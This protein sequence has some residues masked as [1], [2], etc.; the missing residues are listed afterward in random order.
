MCFIYVEYTQI[1]Y[2]ESILY[3]PHTCSRKATE[4]YPVEV[5]TMLHREL[6]TQ[7][8]SMHGTGWLWNDRACI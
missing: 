3:T 8:A 4:T 2:T 5:A 1:L 7:L 6:G